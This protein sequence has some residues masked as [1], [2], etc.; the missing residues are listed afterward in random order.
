MI[1]VKTSAISTTQK[2]IISKE[3]YGT[4]I[5]FLQDH[6]PKGFDVPTAVYNQLGKKIEVSDFDYKVGNDEVIVLVEHQLAAAIFPAL[7][8]FQAWIVNTVVMM[9]VNFAISKLFQPD[10][11]KE[12]KSG[13]TVYSLNNSQNRAKLGETIPVGYG[14]FRMYPSYVEQPYYKYINNEEYLYLLLCVGAGRYN[15]KKLMIDSLDMTH[16]SDVKYKIVKQENLQNIK[17]YVGDSEYNVRNNTLSTP[18]NMDMIPYK[19][20]IFYPITEGVDHLEFDYSYPNGYFNVGDDGAYYNATL[21]L[22]IRFYNETFNT[23]ASYDIV[24]TGQT[25]EVFR[26]TISYVVEPWHK[27]FTIKNTTIMGSDVWNEKSAQKIFINRVKEKYLTPDCRDYGDVTLLWAKI[28]ATNAISS[29]GQQQVNGFFTRG[30]KANDVKNVLKDIYTNKDYSAGLNVGDL[31]FPAT[32]QTV[33]GVF[34]SK[35]TIFDSMRKVAQA[36]RFT[37]YPVGQDVLL[38]YDDVNNITSSL[39]NETNI[40]KGTFSIQYNFKDVVEKYDCVECNYR[41]SEEWA[42]TTHRYPGS[43]LKPRKID[44]FGVTEGTKAAE[45]AK[46]FWKQDAARS[47][48]IKFDTDIQAFNLEYL[49]KIKISHSALLWGYA[50]HVISVDPFGVHVSEYVEEDSNITFR[51]I[52][53]TPSDTIAFTKDGDYTI[54]VPLLP[55]WVKAETPFTIGVAKEFLVIGVDP[56]DED[57]ATIE[58]IEYMPDIYT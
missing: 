11:I 55:D 13:S 57:T 53:G 21:R 26:R 6:Y 40:L 23:S 36:Q 43:G 15:I 51:D 41:E 27:F 39:F 44:L 2:E 19:R 16:V 49:D 46:Y 37:V 32:T 56:K 54:N 5:E 22:N 47:K 58:C 35:Q 34:E 42:P 9:A 1:W 20:T 18:S 3:D 12:L 48:V 10:E 14:T 45:M 4:V 29:A 7:T 33:N 25:R 52:D 24:V 17:A 38:K 8:I 28:K 30:D 50:G 31:H